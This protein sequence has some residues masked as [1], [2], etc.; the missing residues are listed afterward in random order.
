MKTTGQLA[1][2]LMLRAETDTTSLAEKRALNE[3]VTH[4]AV[5]VGIA[6]MVVNVVV[7]RVESATAR[8]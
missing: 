5:L 2:P 3:T 6:G 7:V 8:S 1:P 4:A